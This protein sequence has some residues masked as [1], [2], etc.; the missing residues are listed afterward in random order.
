[1]AKKTYVVTH[2][3]LYMK[4]KD[5]NAL[6][7]VALQTELTIEVEDA[8]SLEEQGKIELKGQ[9]KKVEI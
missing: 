8:A 6:E 5:S 7:H 2:P 1:M 3:K 9:G 4:Q